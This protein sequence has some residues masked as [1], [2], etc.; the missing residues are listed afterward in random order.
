MELKTYQTSEIIELAWDDKVSFDSILEMTGL[1][2]KE[3]IA[4][5]RSEMKPS[6]FRMWRK[7]VGG[8]V[9]KHRAKIPNKNLEKNNYEQPE[10]L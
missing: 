7:R 2:E 5:M 6:S 8:R 3:V 10:E 4:L 1:P 9:A